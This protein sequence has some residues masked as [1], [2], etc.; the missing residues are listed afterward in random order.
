MSGPAG[1]DRRRFLLAGGAAVAVAG[2]GLSLT[3][4][5]DGDGGPDG[6]AALF[7]DTAP[8]VG[9]IGAR[10]LEA[11]AYPDAAAARAALPTDGLVV[12]GDEVDLQDQAAFAQAFQAAQA[13]ELAEGELAPVAGYLFTPTELAVAVV[14]HDAQA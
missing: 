4:C 1:L 12:D 7:G 5:S 13:A 11:G 6:L 3:A 9:A 8:A 14:V 10:A 2:L